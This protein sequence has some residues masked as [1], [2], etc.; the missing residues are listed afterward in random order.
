VQ[1]GYIIEGNFV[2]GSIEHGFIRGN[3]AGNEF[4]YEG[5]IKGRLMHGDGTKKF[6]HPELPW[7]V[8]CKAEWV[9]G[10]INLA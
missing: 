10:E 8:H 4:V 5:D 3:K 1:F 9:Q 2:N 6:K 7:T